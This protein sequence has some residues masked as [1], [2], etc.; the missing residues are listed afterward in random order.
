M[1]LAFEYNYSD[2]IVENDSLGVIDAINCKE[3]GTSCF[4]LILDDI[5]YLAKYFNSCSWCFVGILGNIRD[6]HLLNTYTFISFH[7]NKNTSF[8]FT[9]MLWMGHYLL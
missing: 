1:K 8:F 3:E 2:I 4:H 6:L 9:K 5:V 7:S